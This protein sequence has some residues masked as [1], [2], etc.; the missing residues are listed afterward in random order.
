MEYL[1]F[2][3]KSR[4]AWA[5]I[6]TTLGVCLL[7]FYYVQH[8]VGRSQI[9]EQLSTW[10]FI[11][12]PTLS[13][14]KEQGFRLTYFAQDGPVNS[15]ASASELNVYITSP[16]RFEGY[17]WSPAGNSPT[18]VVKRELREKKSKTKSRDWFVGNFPFVSLKQTT[19]VSIQ[20][21]MV[22]V[23]FCFVFPMQS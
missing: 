13:P 16:G 3:V 20:V 4:R 14:K 6:Y 18:H 2:Q 15:P 22:F 19:N 10:S 17:L 11:S 21:Q 5:C 12:S 9:R 1:Y 8:C 23:L 7:P